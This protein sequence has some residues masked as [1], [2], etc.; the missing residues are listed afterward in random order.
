MNSLLFFEKVSFILAGRENWFSS[1]D[2]QGVK[3]NELI[4]SRG[5][6]ENKM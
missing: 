4:L 3:C 1:I 5:C 2:I 6:L